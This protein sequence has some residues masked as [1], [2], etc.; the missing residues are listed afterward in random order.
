[1][2]NRINK[3]ILEHLCGYTPSRQGSV[4]ILTSP[5][6]KEVLFDSE[7]PN[8]LQDA[9]AA[10]KILDARYP[11]WDLQKNGKSYLCTI[12]SPIRNTGKEE[13]TLAEAICRC[14]FLHEMGE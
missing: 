9:E 7:I 12:R 1:M 3:W 4:S 5:D 2:N 11:C 6:G 8:L 13:T 14:I 10:L